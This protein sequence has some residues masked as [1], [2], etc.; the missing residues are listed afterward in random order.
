LVLA[1]IGRIDR[2][3]TLNPG[4]HVKRGQPLMRLRRGEQVVEITSPATGV[5]DGW[6]L[7]LLQDPKL[8]F[9][10]VYDEAGWLVEIRPEQ[11]EAELP[12]FKIARETAQW[13]QN[14]LGRLRALAAEGTFAAHAAP[15]MADGGD[16]VEGFLEVADPAGWERFNRLFLHSRPE[17]EDV[18]TVEGR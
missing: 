17:P 15:V 7:P 8:A 13:L 12:L 6:N 3:E 2:V 9:E 18:S 4:T 14:E 5:V 1:A 10:R 16:P 11:L